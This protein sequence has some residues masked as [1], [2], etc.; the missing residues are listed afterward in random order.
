MKP[1]KSWREKLQNSKDLPKVVPLTGAARE[2]WG[3]ATLAI[4]PPA[5]IDALMKRVPRGRVT[6][7]ND[8]RA[9]VARAHKAEVGCPI[10]AGIFAWISANAAE[11]AVAAGAKRVTP[12][13]RT[14]KKDGELNAKYPGGLSGH[15]RRLAAEGHRFT[16][17][18][19]RLFVAD[20][21]D[22]LFAP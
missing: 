16:T 14:L 22:S 18:G 1:K 6:T 21:A 3:G 13:W 7:I 12:W 15:K 10:T 5:E 19:K 2:R 20:F 17:R 4:A 8:L 11:E 9:A